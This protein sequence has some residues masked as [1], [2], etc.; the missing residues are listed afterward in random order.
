MATE[1][2][3]AFKQRGSKLLKENGHQPQRWHMD[4]KDAKYS[5]LCTRCGLSALLEIDNDQP[6]YSG[7]CCTVICPDGLFIYE[8]SPSVELL[9]DENKAVS[10]SHEW[11]EESVD[12]DDVPSAVK[13]LERALEVLK[14]HA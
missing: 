5:T 10:I 1:Q 12:F 8:V 3:I 9:V 13:A 7:D 14:S 6:K 4:R 2:T 11:G